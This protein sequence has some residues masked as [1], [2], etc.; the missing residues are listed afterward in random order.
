MSAT[1]I[2]RQA[3]LAADADLVSRHP[4]LD[5]C[6]AVALGLFAG[7]WLWMGAVAVG[8]WS[9][10]LSGWLAV[11]AIALGLSVLHE[12]EHDL[13][14]DLYLGRWPAVRRAVLAGIWV[15]KASLAPWS[16][17]RIHRWHHVVS[18]QP[19]DIE[20]RLIGLGLPWGPRRL[21]LT[22]LPL[23]SV[24]VAAD[25]R[26]AVRARRKAGGR[27]PDLSH[28]PAYRG[29]RAIDTLFVFL[30]LVAVGGWLAGAGWAAPLLVLWVLPNTLRHAAIVSMSSSSH[31]TDIERGQ[32]VQQNQILDHPLFWPL[33]LF[34]WN[35]GA[36]H[37]LHHFVVQQPFWRRTLVFGSVRDT[38]VE[39]GVRAND[40]GSFKRANR[41]RRSQTGPV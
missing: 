12:L 7:A 38:L 19:E 6:D 30:P 36:T 27:T 31:Y 23:G 32:L 13:I 1:R 39:Q 28:G 11:P 40:L 25:I 16:R 18:G 22:V 15:G 5:R 3:I 9:L 24:L 33:Q 2:I 17:G 29:V 4:W 41:W 8:W 20:E 21:L 14:H 35:F 37:V 26:R 10:G 34:C